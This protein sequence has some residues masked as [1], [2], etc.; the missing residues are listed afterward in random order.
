MRAGAGGIE[1]IEIAVKDGDGKLLGDAVPVV[2]IVKDG[3]YAGLEIGDDPA[4]EA[5]IATSIDHKL[6][7]GRLAG[8]VY[9]GL[10]PYGLPPSAARRRAGPIT[11][12]ATYRART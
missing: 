4:L 1:R 5:D 12:P 9:E 3:G 8:F 7:L 11:T 6:G 2:S 10:A